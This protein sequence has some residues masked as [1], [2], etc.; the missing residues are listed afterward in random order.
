VA[1]EK[2]LPPDLAAALHRLDDLVQRF[3]AHPDPAVQACAF[4]LLQCVDAVHRAGI[5]RL[6]GLLAEAGLA[7]RALADPAVA[8]LLELYGLAGDR[9]PAET[10]PRPTPAPPPGFVPLSSINLR[11]GSVSSR[12]R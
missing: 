6:A 8:L 2:P 3:E 9:E 7:E 1:P 11:R 10:A 4:E 5:G 12:E